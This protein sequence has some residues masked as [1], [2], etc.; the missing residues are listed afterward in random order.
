MERLCALIQAERT[1]FNDQFHVH[2]FIDG[3][4]STSWWIF[5]VFLTQKINGHLQQKKL[6]KILHFF[7]DWWISGLQRQK[8]HRDI[9]AI[10]KFKT[11]SIIWCQQYIPT[12]KINS[13]SL[14]VNFG[15]TFVTLFANKWLRRSQK[16]KKVNAKFTDK[17]SPIFG[18]QNRQCS[19][20]YHAN[21]H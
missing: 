5:K 14:D 4:S 10:V 3:P 9:I 16:N 6:P 12:L 13:L 7:K 11:F 18:L 15:P 21:H 8:K 17:F 19:P 20:Y 2:I 1:D